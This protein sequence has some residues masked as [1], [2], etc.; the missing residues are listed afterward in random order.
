MKIKE[1]PPCVDGGMLARRVL[2]RRR[3]S[4]DNTHQNCDGRDSLTW[5]YGDSTPQPDA[6]VADSGCPYLSSQ[7]ELTA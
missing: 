4:H 5:G 3:A 7:P 2:Q 6:G 1:R